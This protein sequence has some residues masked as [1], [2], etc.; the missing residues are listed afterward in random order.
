MPL[1]SKFSIDTGPNTDEPSLSGFL[2]EV[3]LVSDIDDV[4][5]SDDRT[6]LM[7]LHS[8][9][10]L[11][12]ERVYIAGCEDGVFPSY[13]TVM[14]TDPDAIEEERRLAYVGITRAKQDLT[15]TYA[16]CRMNKGEFQ[17]NPVSRFIREIPEEFLDNTLPKTKKA[18]MDSYS[19][20]SY[21]RSTFKT[22]PFSMGG[23]ISVGFNSFGTSQT[24]P[25]TVGVSFGKSLDSLTKGVTKADKLDYEVGDRV[26][27][28]KY[29]E[30][31][32]LGIENDVKDYKVTVE[33]D[34]A[35]KKVMY[36]MFAKLRKI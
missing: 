33:F 24:K 17:Y 4:D 1:R 30:G 12:F 36:A 19:E 13:M 8:A 29:G 10:G 18:D 16:K 21:E 25:S 6:L 9:K 32:V 11:E 15:I 34:S 26:R 20:D 14:D 2:E 22:K 7:T 31:T 5:S 3:A 35:G 27:H 28:I 23:G